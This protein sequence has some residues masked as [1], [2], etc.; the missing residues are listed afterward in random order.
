MP[1]NIYRLGEFVDRVACD[2]IRQSPLRVALPGARQRKAPPHLWRILGRRGV[3]FAG[4]SPA[5]CL[6]RF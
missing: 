3:H 5:D 2:T 1:T 6:N 4:G